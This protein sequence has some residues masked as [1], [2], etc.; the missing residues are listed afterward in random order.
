MSEM[1]N[2]FTYW[3]VSTLTLAI[4]QWDRRC[5]W[6]AEELILLLVTQLLVLAIQNNER[7]AWGTQVMK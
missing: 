7:E 4:G 5:L 3:D 6:D 2:R 1:A